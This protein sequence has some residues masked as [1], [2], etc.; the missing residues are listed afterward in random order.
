MRLAIL[1]VPPLPFHT[2]LS[3]APHLLFV[4][5]IFDLLDFMTSLIHCSGSF[6]GACTISVIGV[7]GAWSFLTCQLGRSPGFLMGISWEIFHPL[8]PFLVFFGFYFPCRPFD[9]TGVCT[10]LSLI[11]FSS[12]L[13]L[14]LL[15]IFF[16]FLLL[17]L[18]SLKVANVVDF[19]R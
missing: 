6:S 3:I 4:Q 7:T 10:S 14:F 13:F 12:C 16:T 17:F 11:S 15:I 8:F 19:I 5:A 2:V 1:P 9:P 18:L